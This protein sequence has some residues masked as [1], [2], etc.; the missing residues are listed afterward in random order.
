M[1]FALTSFVADGIRAMGPG[2]VQAYQRYIFTI[3]GL[4]TDVELDIGDFTGTFWTA[5]QAD[6]TLVNTTTTL[7]QMAASVL[8]FLTQNYPNYSAVANIF[9]PEIWGRVVAAAASGSAYVRTI[10]ITLLPNFTFAASNGETA[11]TVI[12]DYILNPGEKPQVFSSNITV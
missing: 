12:V 10:D 7:G 11:Y 8:S 4:T 6:T 5:A 3:T 9:V 2:P 1:S